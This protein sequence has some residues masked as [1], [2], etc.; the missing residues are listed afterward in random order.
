MLNMAC[1]TPTL[2][3][4]MLELVSQI[5]MWGTNSATL[6]TMSY[7]L[8]PEQLLARVNPSPVVVFLCFHIGAHWTEPACQMV[9]GLF[10]SPRLSYRMK[11]WYPGGS[12]YNHVLCRA[13]KL[14]SL[15]KHEVP[16][17][18]VKYAETHAHPS[19]IRSRRGI[20][21]HSCWW[22]WECE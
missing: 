9:L 15:S 8:C 20:R 2:T 17:A 1:E 13:A 3:C 5:E 7:W 16:R 14:A 11:T 21:A 10:V 18:E 19:L 4:S 6:D 22:Y 12:P